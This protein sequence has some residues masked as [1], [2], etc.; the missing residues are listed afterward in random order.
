MTML[1]SFIFIILTFITNYVMILFL[2]DDWF[3]LLSLTM[4]LSF[5][6]RSQLCLIEYT[7]YQQTFMI[8]RKKTTLKFNFNLLCV[9]S[10][11]FPEIFATV[12]T[13]EWCQNMRNF[14]GKNKIKQSRKWINDYYQW[15][16]M[17]LDKFQ[18]NFIKKT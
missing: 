14:I 12:W 4:L 16:Y 13:R 15:N 1:Q 6:N 5:R 17:V 2:I 9:C 18:P 3:E 7:N 10:H 8:K 11:Q